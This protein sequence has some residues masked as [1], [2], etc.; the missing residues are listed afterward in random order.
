MNNNKLIKSLSLFVLTVFIAA[1][2]L[3]FTSCSDKN[4]TES[5]LSVQSGTVTNVTELGQ[6][7]NSFSFTVTDEQGKSSYFKIHT[8]C[9]T[10]G[11]ALLELDLISGEQ[12]DYGLYV[13]TVN[14]KTF[15]YDK[16]GKYWS[17]YVNGKYATSGV[18]LTK[19]DTNSTYS[20]KVE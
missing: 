15:D 13:K 11:E 5:L 17:F 20:F 6:G 3:F 2:A 9:K 8:D 7:A 14:G 18:D 10:V 4:N 19:I 16:D 1:N 12:G